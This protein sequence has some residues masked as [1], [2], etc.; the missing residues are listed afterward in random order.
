MP[1]Q[2]QALGLR[3]R[4]HTYNLLIKACV[5]GYYCFT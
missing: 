2:L 3:P 5:A 1:E 4:T